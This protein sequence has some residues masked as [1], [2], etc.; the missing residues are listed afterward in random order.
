MLLTCKERAK[1]KNLGS[2]QVTVQVQEAE[3]KSLT[4]ELSAKSADVLSLTGDLGK[5]QQEVATLSEKLEAQIKRRP[6]GT[7]LSRWHAKKMVII[8]CFFFHNWC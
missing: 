1:A 4:T 3:L 5:R 8:S 2:L 6:E 7:A